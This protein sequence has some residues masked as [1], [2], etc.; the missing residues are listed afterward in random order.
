[1]AKFKVINPDGTSKTIATPKPESK[2]IKAVVN[3]A[4]QQPMARKI[5]KAAKIVEEPK[6]VE[7]PIPPTEYIEEKPKEV[8][9]IDK[10]LIE[11]EPKMDP[12]PEEVVKLVEPVPEPPKKEEPTKIEINDKFSI[13][14]PISRKSHKYDMEENPEKEVK[15]PDGYYLV[16]KEELDKMVETIVATLSDT[17]VSRDQL[18]TEVQQAIQKMVIS[19]DL[20]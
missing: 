14:K 20:K 3:N 18:S 13:L 19:N 12:V 15:I 2:P 6:P 1:M 8:V 5:A 11:R 10:S 9:S 16:S 7:K 4:P 17:F